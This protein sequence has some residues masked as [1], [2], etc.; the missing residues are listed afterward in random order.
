MNEPKFIQLIADYGVGDPS[1]G[2]VI[3]KLSS[4]AP[5][6]QVFP[7]SVP[8][9]NTIA[10]GFWTYQYSLVNTFSEMIIYTNT[11]PR[12]DNAEKRKDNEG[13]SLV[14]AKL[15]NGMQV[16]G[17]NAGYCFSFIKQDIE[18]LHLVNVANKGSQ[19]RSRDFYPEA[20]IGIAH[21]EKKFIGD[22]L[23]PSIIPDIPTNKIA[24]V[25]G[26]GNIKTT[27]RQSQMKAYKS[28]QPVLV[29]LGAMKRTAW[30]SDGT[31]SV[32]EGELAFAP[33]SSGGKDRFMELFLRGLSAWKELGKP[34]GDEELTIE[35]FE[36]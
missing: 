3:Q 33:G 8:S 1:F 29:T 25:D 30:F 26:Y 35:E 22:I 11:A 28:G 27:V 20:V 9:F 7:T 15:K 24:W 31:F 14:Y 10:T 12:K 23:K 36:Q 19:F 4:L 34:T 16:V 18:A 32:R 13:E 2:E 17:V 6:V 21:G 5:G